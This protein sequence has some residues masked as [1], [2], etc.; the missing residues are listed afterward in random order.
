MQQLAGER[1][2]DALSSCDLEQIHYLGFVQPQGFLV[3]A[4][5][6]WITTRTSAN[7]EQFLNVSPE[8]VLGTPLS[9]VLGRDMLHEIRGQLQMLGH[10]SGAQRLFGSDAL[11]GGRP[12]DLA[13]HR[14]GESL[15][16]EGEPAVQGD[17]QVAGFVQTLL[18]QLRHV[19]DLARLCDLVVRQ[20]R[21]L[22]GFDRVMLYRFHEDLSGEVVA[23]TR[24]GDLAP[25]KGLRYPASDIPAQA[26]ALYLRN[27]I[28]LI[29]DV[30]AEPV[31]VLPALDPSGRPIDLSM[32]VLRA[33]SPVHIQYLRNMQV[34]ASL[35]I[36]VLS[37]GRLWG[38]IACHHATP[39][40]LS[41]QRRTAL[42]FFGEMFS[43]L[44]ESRARAEEVARREEARDFQTRMISQLSGETGSLDDVF[45]HL[46]GV[47]SMLG[48]DGLATFIDG[49]L[50][51]AG[52]TPGTSEILEIMRFL[53]RAAASKVYASHALSLVHPPAAH[54]TRQGCGVLAI[55][56]SRRPRDYVV[57]F[58]RELVQQVTWAGEPAKAVRR[59]EGT[60]QLSPRASFAAWRETVRGQSAH[61]SA[62]DLAI[63]EALRMTLLEL[64]LQVTDRAEKQRK[65]SNDQ[66]DLLIAELN[67]R[68]R[69]ILNLIVG[70]VRQCGDSATSVESFAEEVSARVHALARAHDQ[71][72]SSGWGARSL[73][74]MIRV[75]AGAY[76][77]AKAERVAIHGDDVGIQPDA[78]AT[79]AL[80]M[81]ELI[82]NAAKYGAF[83]DSRG[84]V[85]IALRNDPDKGLDIAWDEIG[86]APITPPTR[87][88][89][90]STIIERA[91]PHELM[92]QARVDFAP[93]GLRARF[94]IPAAFIEVLDPAAPG[95]NA[96][97]TERTQAKVERLSG[98][99]LLVEDNLLIALET[100]AMLG[101]LGAD[102]VHVASTVSAALS[103]LAENRPHFAVLDYNLGRERSVPI[104]E[105]LSAMQVPFVFATGYGDTATIDD[106]FR[107]RPILTKP[108]TASSVL[109]AWQAIS[110]LEE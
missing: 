60:Q 101:S 56:V 91:I 48:A 45:Q 105:R 81:H 53:N 93:A 109:R 76:L 54:Y 79:V 46:V 90:G 51:T 58:R 9:E 75:E 97:A 15:V 8:A 35:S 43:F 84:H 82:T 66:Q 30:A 62:G 19:P 10:G 22:T 34:G 16:I 77:G 100:E 89:F 70:L 41:L 96:Q 21:A 13:I 104:A 98:D 108:Y 83:R 68:V 78:F 63:A 61:W 28:R 92:G 20:M 94:H 25:F 87:R 37:G 29:A 47:Q 80:V 67:H 17:E 18:G 85:E 49:R 65:L 39:R 27:P 44:L 6:D 11:P 55:P 36:S 33:V 72:T 7:L 12:F 110:A 14:A 69:N 26:R 86:G 3:E 74:T 38:L 42:E 107:S 40:N 99:I 57:F 1:W 23:E 2:K 32:S 73:A 31:P 95:A 24:R 59:V 4:S 64:M 88:G 50:R 103:Y 5:A 102:N 71:L 106:R 52:T